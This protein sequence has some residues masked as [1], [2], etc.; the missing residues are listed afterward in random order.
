MR[1]RSAR[2]PGKS[3]L[4]GMRTAPTTKMTA[5]PRTEKEVVEEL[6]T[7][8]LMHGFASCRVRSLVRVIPGGH[9]AG[10]GRVLDDLL[11]E[12]G[13]GDGEP[14]SDFC[15]PLVGWEGVL[16]ETVYGFGSAQ[17]VVSARG[18]AV[19]GCEEVSYEVDLAYG[20]HL[21]TV[22]ADGV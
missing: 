14:G 16:D 9:V 13:H 17:G 15:H 1:R 7:I 4:V 19:V 11:L 5:M 22:E 6:R 3:K 10:S 20:Y 12:F 8:W 21:G 2:V 18:D